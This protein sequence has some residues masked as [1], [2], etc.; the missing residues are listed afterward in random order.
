MPKI[1]YKETDFAA[2]SLALIEQVNDIIDT[3]RAQGYDLTLR[4]VYYQM[5]ARGIVPNTE[6][7]YKNL[8]ELISNARLAGMIDWDAIEDRTRNL[9]LNSHWTSPGDIMNS[10]ARS[11]ALDKWADQEN[12]IECWVEKEA[13]AGVVGQICTQLD[14]PFFACKGYV[15]QSEMWGAA[16]RIKERAN[17]GRGCILLYLG[18]HDPSG[19][20]MTRDIRDRLQLFDAFPTLYRIALNRDQIEQ[21]NPPP[22]PAK[23]T[24]S[25]YADYI[26]TH[27][28]KSW[29]LD[30]LEPA[31]ITALIDDRVSRY[32]DQEKWDAVKERESGQR[33]LLRK[34]SRNWDKLRDYLNAM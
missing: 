18:D 22:N 10:A 16:Q 6:R 8:G 25:R 3:Y 27:G 9:R 30:A 26:A 24:D 21:Y 17:Q 2:T 14:V 1:A 15:S 20:D 34:A 29:E 12:Y 33:A 11:Y 13:L 4:Q 31:V 23:M 28:T 32:R 19:I 7:S 5:V